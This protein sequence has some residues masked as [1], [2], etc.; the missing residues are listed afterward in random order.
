MF[1]IVVFIDQFDNAYL[2]EQ[3]GVGVGFTKQFQK[4]TSKELAAAVSRVTTDTNGTY[5][6]AA[7]SIALKLREDNGAEAVVDEVERYWE[8]S[9]VTGEW[10]KAPER[11]MAPNEAHG[12]TSTHKLLLVATIG[13]VGGAFA[14]AHR[15][16][17]G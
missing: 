6:S 15:S 7:Q 14:F 16:K 1:L 11:L 17:R 2:V 10:Q 12:M 4:I 5:Q 3:L 9:V 13:V 8:E